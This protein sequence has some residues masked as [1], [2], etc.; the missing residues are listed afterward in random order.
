M[1]AQTAL[2]FTNT[3]YTLMIVSAISEF[4]MGLLDTGCNVA[5]LNLMKPLERGT[6]FTALYFAFGLGNVFGPALAESV[7]Q[8]D[9]I[10]PQVPS[11][12]SL[13]PKELCF[14][15]LQVLHSFVGGLV[16][17][18]VLAFTAFTIYDLARGSHADTFKA[19]PEIGSHLPRK[20]CHVGVVTFLMSILFCCVNGI[21]FSFSNFLT[22]FVMRSLGMSKSR[23]SKATTIYFLASV[24]TKMATI[25]GVTY[26]SPIYLLCGSVLLL[27]TSAFIFFCTNGTTTLFVCVILVGISV[28]S[29]FSPGLLW[30]N[31][32]M[33]ISSKKTSI[34]LITS[35]IGAQAFKIPIA[36]SIELEPD[37]LSY[38]VLSGSIV[39]SITFG[40]SFLMLKEYHIR[41]RALPDPRKRLH[42]I[43]HV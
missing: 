16:M 37:I 4:S 10:T 25:I 2:A 3:F 42:G 20:G 36:G 18:S 23:G 43:S 11:D 34:F 8:N 24:F 38:Y 31:Q 22:V 14:N 13:S 15:D 9:P 17:T 39:V 35:S 19:M 6:Y 5:T 30:L 32:N 7:L 41:R 33:H 26:V 40:F 28:S 27:L 21:N 29:I 1:I 12:G